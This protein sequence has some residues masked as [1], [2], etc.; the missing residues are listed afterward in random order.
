MKKSRRIGAVIAMA[1]ATI[2]MTSATAIAAAT[3]ADPR[4]PEPVSTWLRPVRAHTDTWIDINWRT[5][6]RVC[7]ASVKYYGQDIDIEY[8]GNRRSATFSRGDTLS[9]GRGDSTRIQVNPDVDRSTLVKLR[10]VITYD[11][12]GRKAKKDTRSFTLTLPVQRNDRPGNDGRPGRPGNDGNDGN[13][14]GRPGNNSGRP[15]DNDGA[16]NN[17]RPSN[18]DRPSNDR[19]TSGQ[20]PNR[21][22]ATPTATATASPAVTPTATPAT[23]VPVATVPVVSPPASPTLPP[24]V[25][26]DGDHQRGP[27]GHH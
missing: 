26:H 24:P 23:T 6:Q 3:A 12:C 13:D 22:T 21:P 7:E 11:T 8:R 17:G 25:R 9:P 20:R 5:K 1:T 19:P 14:N 15:G 4:G 2:G 16:G 27:R 18:N 10:A